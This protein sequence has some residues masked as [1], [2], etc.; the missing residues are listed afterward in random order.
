VLEK[1]PD[2]FRPKGNAAGVEAESKGC[3]CVRSNC[4]KRYCECFEAGVDCT[5]K[6]NCT[7]CKNTRTGGA[8]V[9]S[10]SASAAASSAASA[11]A[12]AGAVVDNDLKFLELSPDRSL[13]ASRKRGRDEPKSPSKSAPSSPSKKQAKKHA[14]KLENAQIERA[15]FSSV[16]Q[17]EHLQSVSD[18]LLMSA[19]E[20]EA[21]IIRQ[22]AHHDVQGDD[23]TAAVMAEIAVP[24][25]PPK[26][27]AADDQQ[28]PQP[29]SGTVQVP[30]K[31]PSEVPENLMCFEEDALSPSLAAASTLPTPTALAPAT[32][33]NSSKHAAAHDPLPPQQPPAQSI[34]SHP[35]Y[36]EQEKAILSGL[37]ES[38]TTIVDSVAQRKAQLIQSSVPSSPMRGSIADLSLAAATVDGEDAELNFV[39]FVTS[40]K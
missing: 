22:L 15:L 23:V 8:A 24:P 33:S 31:L 26:Q 37:L 4:L 10:S 19:R 1:N 5:D 7:D 17:P 18:I 36:I 6:C 27:S 13:L 20:T 21:R 3:N 30:V 11:S 40:A 25:S 35:L 2:A 28:P 9:L 14:R 39:H 38:L 34:T 32:P 16:L 29:P 12:A